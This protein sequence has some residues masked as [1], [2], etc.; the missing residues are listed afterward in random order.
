MTLKPYIHG[1]SEVTG[2]KLLVENDETGIMIITGIVIKM[3]MRKNLERVL[4]F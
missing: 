1:L 2:M 4:I 3:E